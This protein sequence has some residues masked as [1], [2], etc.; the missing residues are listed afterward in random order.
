MMI[1]VLKEEEEKRRALIAEKFA[2][3]REK[4]RFGCTFSF[5]CRGK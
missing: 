5:C 4:V 2:E 3:S 1:E